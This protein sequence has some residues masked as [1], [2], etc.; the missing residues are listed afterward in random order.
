MLPFPEPLDLELGVATIATI[1]TPETTTTVS[2]TPDEQ[3]ELLSINNTETLAIWR[4][5]NR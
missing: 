4:H 2:I 5:F 3:T 1:T